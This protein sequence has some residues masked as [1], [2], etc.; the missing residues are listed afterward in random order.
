MSNGRRFLMSYHATGASPNTRI[1]L[2]TAG[3]FVSD[4]E[5]PQSG[6]EQEG[7]P[8]RGLGSG[9]MK[10]HI[11]LHDTASAVV[12]APVDLYAQP[13]LPPLPPTARE[14]FFAHTLK[15]GPQGPGGWGSASE[16]R[17]APRHAAR[18][19]P[20]LSVAC[21]AKDFVPCVAERPVDHPSV[22]THVCLCTVCQMYAPAIARASSNSEQQL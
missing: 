20:F 3:L 2:A 4:D 12:S 13:L 22:C 8:P 10:M 15:P 19:R 7:M 1:S 6:D 5:L 21:Y 17:H 18:R 14:P 9:L 11:N 16:P